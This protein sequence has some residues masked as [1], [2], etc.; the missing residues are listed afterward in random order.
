MLGV[1]V[2]FQKNQ[3]LRLENTFLKAARTRAER[4]WLKMKLLS[5]TLCDQIVGEAIP[6]RLGADCNCQV[7][8]T[9]SVRLNGMKESGALAELLQTLTKS[10]CAYQITDGR[11]S[12]TVLC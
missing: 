12:G 4:S 11:W 7:I 1:P 6:S 8:M 5:V 3:E 10:L 2:N 9:M